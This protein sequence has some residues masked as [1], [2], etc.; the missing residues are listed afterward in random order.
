MQLDQDFF[1]SKHPI[2]FL[3]EGELGGKAKGLEFI[4]SIISE[5]ISEEEEEFPDFEITI[6]KMVVIRTDVFDLFMKTNNLY[7]IALSDASDDRIAQAF[8]KADLPFNILGDLRL[9]VTEVTQ[10]LAVRSSS[11]LEDAMHEPFA[12]IYGT[13]LTPNNQLDIDTRF[14]KLTEA[15]KYVYASTFFKAPKNYI[16]ATKNNTEDEKMAVIIQEVVGNEHQKRFYPEIS[17]VARSYNFYPP[18]EAKPEDGV[19]NLALGLGKTIVDGGVSWAYSPSF[20][21]KDPPFKSIRDMLKQTQ[22]KFWSVNLGQLPEYDPVNETE[23][24]FEKYLTEAEEDG[25]L[26]QLVSTYDAQADRVWT[27]KSGV[28][29]RIMTFAPILKSETIALNNLIKKL[30]T[31][32]EGA[33]NSPVETEF[34]VTENTSGDK[35]RYKFGFLQVRP[36]VVSSEEVNIKEKEFEGK[37]VLL[38]SQHVLGNGTN[39]ELIDIVYLKIGNFQAKYTYKIARELEEINKK[40]IAENKKYLLIGF[41]RWGT[42]DPWAGIPVDW[43]QISAAKIIVETAVEQMMQ[44]MSQASHFF[45]N[46]TSF[47]VSYFS[48]PF[49]EHKKI[50]WDWLYELE[51][52][53]ET[54][55]IRH[56]KTKKPLSIKVDGRTGKGIILKK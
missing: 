15:V 32:C 8:Q 21:K 29:P 4:H 28:G 9:I 34:A 1:N 22:L 13:K 46:I 39:N 25:T 24:M 44:E 31:V 53:E 33:Y 11:L 48:V 16:K 19:V 45:H 43:S 35:P 42:T 41:G 38:S 51:T 14:R 6:P 56:A 10:P 23:Y 7:D 5:E 37:N 20:P 50:D 40:F 30:L 2:S 17:G 36:M 54:T 27:G 49:R 52:V 26:N 3:G 55:Y 18:G 12:G 47:E